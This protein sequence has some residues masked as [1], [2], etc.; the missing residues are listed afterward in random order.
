MVLVVEGVLVAV[1]ETV[2]VAVVEGVLVAVSDVVLVSAV[3]VVEGVL[4]G[5]CWCVGV[6]VGVD[7]S[8]VDVGVHAELV[9]GAGSLAPSSN[10]HDP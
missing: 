3:D 5:W 7:Q 2:L 1:S 8:G 6:G 9:D 4:A 10:H